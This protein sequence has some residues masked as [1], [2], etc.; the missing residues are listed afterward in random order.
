MSAR[1][2]IDVPSLRV[3]LENRA[4]HSGTVHAGA[5]LARVAPVPAHAMAVFLDDEVADGQ[6]GV[7]ARL[8][9]GR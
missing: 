6:E 8:R 9:A 2:L 3:G 1:P 4:D 7:D 5:E